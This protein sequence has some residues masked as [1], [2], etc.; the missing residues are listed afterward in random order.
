[1]N[2]LE[3]TILMLLGVTLWFKMK[4][5]WQYYLICSGEIADRN[6]QSYFNEALNSSSFLGGLKKFFRFT[7]PFFIDI[8]PNKNKNIKNLKIKIIVLITI[9]WVLL[10]ILAIETLLIR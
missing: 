9:W 3:L 2:I 7:L 1:M 6:I 10:A 5:H 8:Q 4:Y